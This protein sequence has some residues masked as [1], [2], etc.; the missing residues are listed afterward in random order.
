MAIRQK[1][2]QVVVSDRELE[3]FRAYAA[4]QGISMSEIL[5]DYVKSLISKEVRPKVLPHV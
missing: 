5:R 4:E 3:M 1:K 2:I